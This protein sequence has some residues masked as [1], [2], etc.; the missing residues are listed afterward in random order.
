M[1]ELYEKALNKMRE[2][3]EIPNEKEWNVIA[4]FENY[5]SSESLEY[6]SG[7]SFR[8]LCRVT[9]TNN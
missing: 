2:L 3:S 6:I 9:I 1:Q 4:K 7:M 5:L 8:E